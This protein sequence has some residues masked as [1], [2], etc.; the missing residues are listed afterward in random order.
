M[1]LKTIFF[2][3]LIYFLFSYS[4]FLNIPI[5]KSQAK[6]KFLK[7]VDTLI[8]RTQLNLE[9][10]SKVMVVLVKAIQTNKLTQKKKPLV[11]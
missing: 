4:Y 6:S 11:K 8:S 7:N 9:I 5:S 2:F 10:Q 3:T 1:I